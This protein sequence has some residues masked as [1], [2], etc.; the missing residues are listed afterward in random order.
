MWAHLLLAQQT[1]MGGRNKGKWGKPRRCVARMR[2]TKVVSR[3]RCFYLFNDTTDQLGP[4]L[5]PRHS[6]AMSPT[7]PLV[8]TPKP[9]HDDHVDHRMTWQAQSPRSR[10]PMAMRTAGWHSE[11]IA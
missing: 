7:L 1:D 4:P 5:P 9:P 2:Q 11:P 6:H 8:K 3:S 10:P